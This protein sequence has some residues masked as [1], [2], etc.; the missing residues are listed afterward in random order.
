LFLVRVWLLIALI[1]IFGY[2]QDVKREA[3]VIGIGD[4]A[5]ATRNDLNG[6]E[7]DVSKIKRLFKSLGFKVTILYDAQAMKILEYLDRY[8]EILDSNDY[9]AFYYSGHGSYEPDES[10]DELDGRDETLVLSDGEENRHLSDDILNDKFSRIRAKKLIFIDS[11]HSGTAFRGLN[12]GV[13]PKTILPSEVSTRTRGYGRDS[14]SGDF[15]AFSASQDSEESLATPTGSL[16]TDTLSKTLIDRGYI[17]RAIEEIG[18]ILERDILKYAK[19]TGNRP[20]HPKITLSRPDLKSISLNSFLKLDSSEDRSSL[21]S[22][23]DS[24]VDRGLADR[25]DITSDRRVYR[26]GESVKFTVDSGGH[27]GFLTIL[28]IDRDSITTLYPNPY[29]KIKR[30]EGRYIF[31]DNLSG[32]RFELEGYKSCK[33]CD[34]EETTIYAILTEE[35]I[36]DIDRLRS[37]GGLFSFL[38]SSREES[39][40]TRAVRLKV[41]NSKGFK[42][43]IGV[44]RFT[45]K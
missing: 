8:S 24:M 19:E 38:K 36:E 40:V 5:P 9:F 15:I 29:V 45:I 18:L 43:L 44:Y 16:F 2:G 3:L 23:L 12:M 34:S 7:R 6:I 17:N 33:G 20:H 27:K 21:E 1:S 31:P 11:C 42:P 28:Y 4:Y 13:K 37:K 14:I 26:E 41:S 32:G 10:G 22:I 25:L 35:P 39:I 30:V